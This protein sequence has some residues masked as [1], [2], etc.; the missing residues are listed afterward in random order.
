M[1]FHSLLRRQ[2]KR[3]FGSVD[4]VP[5]DIQPLISIISETYHQ[6]DE[7]RHLLERSLELS[8]EELFQANSEMRA[9]FRLFPDIFF[10]IDNQARIIDFNIGSGVKVFNSDSK[11]SG[12]LLF[13]HFDN[14]ICDLFKTAIETLKV[15]H[16]SQTF[17]FKYVLGDIEA[18]FEA[19]LLPLLEREIIIFIKDISRRKLIEEDLQLSKVAA[20]NANRAKS[21]FLANMS[22]EIRTPMNAILGFAE[23]LD[24]QLTDEKSKDYLKGILTGGKNLLSLINDILDLSKIEAGKLNI[25]YE[26][27][28]IFR[29]VSELEQVFR[30][31]INEKGLDFKVEIASNIPPGLF[32]DETRLRQILL[33]LIGNAIKFTSEGSVTVSVNT[34]EKD[35]YGSFVDLIIEVKDTGVGIPENQKQLIFEAFR[36]ME[37][38]STRRFGG[39]GLGLSITRRLVEIMHG[40]ITVESTLGEGSSFIVHLENVSVSAISEHPGTVPE[41]FIKNIYFEPAKILLVEDV[42]YNRILIKGYLEQ[43]DFTILEAENGDQSIEKASIH[44]PDLILMDIQM[45]ILDGYS[46]FKIIRANPYTSHIPVI[47]ITASVMRE[48]TIKLKAEFDSFL[49]KPVRWE[50]L[51]REIA[52]FLKSDLRENSTRKKTN[53]VAS[54]EFEIKYE[55]GSIN[56]DPEIVREAK[57]GFMKK[58][59]EV[60]E[61]MFIDD[62]QEFAEE[63]INS[64]ERLNCSMIREYGIDLKATTET[65]EIEKMQQ[66]VAQFPILIDKI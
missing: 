56:I 28:N 29:L 59:K 37:G 31:K 1:E 53:V 36:Q 39:T 41:S 61:G 62:V 38:Q 52:K 16:K 10:R 13:E 18:F 44:Q 63:L 8:S 47:A 26:P 24:S 48:E 32:L 55:R 7:D 6:Y 9:V 25:V 5:E 46:A 11:F 3:Y 64:A 54:E 65:L 23:L 30:P 45:P 19:S 57:E 66:L 49:A 33:N 20:E 40:K 12:T 17:E 51:I 50:D 58:W 60:S 4:K 21:E 43:F 34:K 35:S 14:E 2:L 15:D 22:H 42:E 27:L